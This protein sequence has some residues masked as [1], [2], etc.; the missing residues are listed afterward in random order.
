MKLVLNYLEVFILGV[1]GRGTGKEEGSDSLTGKASL[2]KKKCQNHDIVG[3]FKSLL[4][5]T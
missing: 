2:R 1:G 3:F 4:C 5:R